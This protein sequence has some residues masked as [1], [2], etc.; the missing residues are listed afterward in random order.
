MGRQSKP[1]VRISTL[2]SEEISLSSV[3]QL[4]PLRKFIDIANGRTGRREHVT[5]FYFQTPSLDEALAAKKI[6]SQIMGGNAGAAGHR[7]IAI[8]DYATQKISSEFGIQLSRLIIHS[9]QGKYLSATSLSCISAA[10]RRLV[11]YLA[12]TLGDRLSRFTIYSFAF[13]DW[14]SFKGFIEQADVVDKKRAFFDVLGIF[15]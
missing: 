2:L 13:D 3:D 14:L 10:L 8:G 7:A 9:F 6:V 15:A 1:P 11:E 4:P 12:T 5:R